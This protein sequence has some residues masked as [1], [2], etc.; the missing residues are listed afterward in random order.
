MT[1]FLVL[2]RFN[3]LAPWPTDPAEMVKLSDMLN[4]QIDQRLKTGEI[5]EFGYFLNGRLGYSISVGESANTFGR[6]FSFYPFIEAEVNEIVSYETA[7][8]NMKVIWKARAEAA[9]K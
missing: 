4:A 5:Q 2:W 9:Q 1:T 7:V 6:V 3:P 8:E